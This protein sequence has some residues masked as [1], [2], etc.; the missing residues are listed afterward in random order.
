[1]QTHRYKLRLAAITHERK[2]I[3]EPLAIVWD[4]RRAL[5]RYAQDFCDTLAAHMRELRPQ[6]EPH[7]AKT[8]SRRKR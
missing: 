2:L 1:V 3:S 5:P 6:T 8:N 7:G 4:Q